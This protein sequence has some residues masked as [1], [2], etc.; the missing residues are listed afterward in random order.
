M[1]P[2]STSKVLSGYTQKNENKHF[3]NLFADETPMRASS[4]TKSMKIL[5]THAYCLRTIIA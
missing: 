1:K 3:I 4:H 2:L 5:L